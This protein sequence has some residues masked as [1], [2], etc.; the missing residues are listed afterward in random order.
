V[1]VDS[2]IQHAPDSTGKKIDT[3]EVTRNDG[4]VF[5]RQRLVIA[6]DENPLQS[7]SAEVRDRK[8]QVD[9][10]SI[11]VLDE[12][13]EKLGRICFALELLVK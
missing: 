13:N 10:H 12:I 2:Y 1:T 5:E 7:G 11:Q 9:G 6:D 4:T 8:L 3:G